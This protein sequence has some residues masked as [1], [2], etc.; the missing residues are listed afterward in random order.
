MKLD[1]YKEKISAV[2]KNKLCVGCGLCIYFSSLNDAKMIYNLQGTAPDLSKISY[3]PEIAWLACPGKG[4]DYPKLYQLHYGNYPDNWLTGVVNNSWVGFASDPKIR[5]V[6]A[7]GGVLTSVLLYLLETDRIDAAILVKQGARDPEYASWVIAKSAEEILSC[8]QSVYTPVSVLDSLMHLEPKKRYAI[9]CLPEQSAALSMVKKLDTK[10]AEQ[11]KYILGPYTGTSLEHGAIRSL[12]RSNKIDD[13]DKITSIKWRA[14]EWPG[15]LEI[16][17]KSG[18]IIRSKK[19]Y[20]NYLIPFYITQVS[21]QSMDFTNEFTDLSVGDAWSPEYEAQ[22]QGF[23]VMISRNS[24]MTD[25]IEEMIG[26]GELNLNEVD[27]L[28][29]T[30]MHG[31]ML[32]F[33]KRGAFIRNRIKILIGKPAPDYGMRPVPIGL[34]RVIVEIFIN[35]IFLIC[36]NNFARG[37]METMP[38]TIMGPVFDRLRLSWKSISKPTKRKKLGN[39]RVFIYEPKWSINKK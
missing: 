30:D 3:L 33:K 7:S 16:I 13:K 37:I 8:S 34:F 18:R 23:S 4:I 5:S 39:L 28:S 22:G 14:G 26:E 20:Y 38:E 24:T 12:L 1:N 29:A 9:T 6:G 2:I 31:H 11:I 36:R 15:Y 35:L 17:T 19:A 25:I 10:I 21:L 32:D 27:I